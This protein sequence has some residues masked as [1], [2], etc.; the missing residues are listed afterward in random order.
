MIVL[1][2]LLYTISIHLLMDSLLHSEYVYIEVFGRESPFLLFSQEDKRKIVYNF[3]SIFLM[4]TLLF[5]YILQIIYDLIV[6]FE[7]NHHFV[8]NLV[9]VGLINE[10]IYVLDYREIWKKEKKSILKIK[11]TSNENLL[12]MRIFLPLLFVYILYLSNVINFKNETLNCL[13]SVELGNLYIQSEYFID[14]LMKIFYF[15]QSTLT[16]LKRIAKKLEENRFSITKRYVNSMQ[17]FF[18][19]RAILTYKANVVTYFY[20]CILLPLLVID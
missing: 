10:M 17:F 8:S 13:F 18:L 5:P 20:L 19:I 9:H 4:I 16:Y 12:K 11:I 15:K 14:N 6:K 3:S 1:L 7:F 2:L